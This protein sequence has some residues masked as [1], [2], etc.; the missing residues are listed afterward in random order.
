MA[1][2]RE[3]K[4]LMGRTINMGNYESTRVD[5]EMAIQ[6]EESDHLDLEYEKLVA[7]VRQKLED[8]VAVF[9]QE[10]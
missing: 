9:D 2:I 7:R 4:V 6:L 10:R 1:K 5:V 3:V 8:E